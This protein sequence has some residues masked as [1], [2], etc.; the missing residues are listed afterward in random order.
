V[1]ALDHE[2]LID[3]AGEGV[4]NGGG[5]A[6]LR[7]SRLRLR[8]CRSL[9]SL[10]GWRPLRGLRRKRRTRRRIVVLRHS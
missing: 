2:V 3:E 9:R 1:P 4:E 10:R 7:G 6:M 5:V 8:G